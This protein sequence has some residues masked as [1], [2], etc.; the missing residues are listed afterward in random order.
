MSKVNLLEM[1]PQEIA[2]FFQSLGEPAYRKK[3]LLQWIWQQ[4]V[5]D[6]IAMTNFP[7]QLRQKLQEIATVGSAELLAHQ[8]SQD[9][10]IK[11]LLALEDQHSVE[12]VILPYE[13]GDSVCLSTQVG[14]R[15]GCGFCASGLPGFIRNL[16]AGEIA[17]QLLLAKKVLLAAKRKLKSMVLMGTGEPL[18]NFN[19][20]VAFLEAV[21]DRE[22]LGMSLRHVTLSTCGLV[23]K[24]LE[25]A[26]HRWPLNLAVS[27]HASN[28]KLRNR[29][30]P[31]NK[32]YPLEELLDACDQYASLTGRRVTYEYILIDGLNDEPRNAKELAGLLKGRLCHV[33][34]IPFNAVS[35]IN[36]RPSPPEKVEKFKQILAGAGINVTVRRRLGEDIAAACGQLRNKYC[37]ERNKG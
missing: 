11:L 19:A 18:D 26:K 5:L 35:E 34:L 3:Q 21:S 8:K 1:T 24:I 14:C 22:R 29:I 13:I 30:M 10:T 2:G 12:T 15:M 17:L 27:L 7:R 16:T 33:N 4:N 37:G 36:F 9:G 28:N 31:I 20:V 25:L 6:F 23:P 32:K